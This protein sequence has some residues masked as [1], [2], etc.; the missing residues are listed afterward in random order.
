MSDFNSAASND[1]RF[2]TIVFGL[3][4]NLI[5]PFQRWSMNVTAAIARLTS[6]PRPRKPWYPWV[7][8]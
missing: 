2:W 3:K 5:V 8:A 7:I 4:T 6:F 1:S